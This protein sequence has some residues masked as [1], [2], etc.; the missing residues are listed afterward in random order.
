MNRTRT[1]AFQIDGK[2]MPAPDRDMES[3]YEDIDS[4]DTG[5]TLVLTSRNFTTKSSFS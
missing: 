3:S 4:N 5:R 2:P 1:N